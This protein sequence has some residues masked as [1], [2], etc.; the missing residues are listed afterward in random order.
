MTVQAHAHLTLHPGNTQSSS[1]AAMFSHRAGVRTW[2][3]THNCTV[4]LLGHPSQPSDCYLPMAA[5][6]SGRPETCCELGFSCLSSQVCPTDTAEG[7]EIPCC[8]WG[9]QDSWQQWL[10]EWKTQLEIGSLGIMASHALALCLLA[11]QA[12]IEAPMVGRKERVSMRS[13]KAQ[14]FCMEYLHFIRFSVTIAMS[15]V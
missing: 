8:T 1:V 15:T 9:S 11:A 4:Y 13:R 7:W 3:L 14:A 12:S 2:F 5:V 10:R 6:A